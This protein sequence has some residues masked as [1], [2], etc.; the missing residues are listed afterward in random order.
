MEKAT[1]EAKV[2]TSWM[3]PNPQYDAAVR[4]FVAA[5]LDEHP[6]KNRF[7]PEF[8]RFHEQVVNWG[9]YAALSK[10]CSN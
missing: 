8:T 3:N 2:H 10:R 9:L 1:H 5:V 7:L 6:K 4:Q